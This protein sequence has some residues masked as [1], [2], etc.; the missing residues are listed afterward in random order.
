MCDRHDVR[1]EEEKREQKKECYPL[2][3]YGSDL[4]LCALLPEVTGRGVSSWLFFLFSCSHSPNSL[5][6]HREWITPLSD[7]LKMLSLFC[8]THLDYAKLALYNLSS[9]RGPSKSGNSLS[10][11]RSLSP[12]RQLISVQTPE[13]PDFLVSVQ[14]SLRDK[15]SDASRSLGSSVIGLF[16]SIGRWT[17]PLDCPCIHIDMSCIYSLFRPSWPVLVYQEQW[18]HCWVRSHVRNSTPYTVKTTYHVSVKDKSSLACMVRL[19]H[20]SNQILVYMAAESRS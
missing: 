11:S 13:T 17:L 1:V 16:L 2:A 9:K 3:L 8:L 14:L 6:H 20:W 18:M 10:L 12:E 5:K 7:N 19:G 15:A 4:L